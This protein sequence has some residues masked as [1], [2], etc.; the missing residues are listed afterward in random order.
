MRNVLAFCLLT[1][2]C[3]STS[4]RGHAD[5][6]GGGGGDLSTITG[7]GCSAQAKLVY[8]VDQNDMLSSFDPGT[9]T[10]NDVGTLQCSSLGTPFSMA[11]DRTATA[12]VLYS[13]GELFQVDTSSAHC[14]KTAFARSNGFSNFGMGFASNTAGSNDETLFIAGGGTLTTQMPTS[15]TLATLDLSTFTATPLGTIQLW[16]ELTG[17]GDANLWGFFP[18][19]ATPRVSQLDKMDGHD[20]KTFMAPSL[21]GTPAA[22]A[23]AFWGGDFWIFLKKTGDASTRVYHMKSSDGSVT[24]AVPNTGRTIVGAGVSTCAP[25]AIM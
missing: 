18:S 3:S 15:S 4:T 8:V 19:A 10:F 6:G 24:V 21:A 20:L 12:W 13:T 5:L 23:F 25:I 16:P 11:V 2:A 14:T 1:A 17:T 9:L 7:D 22:W